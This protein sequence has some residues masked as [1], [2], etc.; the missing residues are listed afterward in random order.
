MKKGLMCCVY[1]RRLA[2]GFRTL[3][4][5]HL[6]VLVPGPFLA[7]QPYIFICAYAFTNCESKRKYTRVC[8]CG[9][10]GKLWRC[11]TEVEVEAQQMDEQ[12]E[13]DEA[14]QA[15]DEGQNKET[16]WAGLD[17]CQR[18]EHKPGVVPQQRYRKKGGTHIIKKK[19]KKSDRG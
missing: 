9:R 3:W 17:R 16:S 18:Y 15:C 7:L 5:S 6:C 14:E 13:G 2:D 12:Q 19:I 8:V 11:L 4:T 1:L 10:R